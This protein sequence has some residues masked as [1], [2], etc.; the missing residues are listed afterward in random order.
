MK[1]FYWTAVAAC[2]LLFENRAC[3]E[4]VQTNGPCGGNIR[5]LAAVDGAVFAGTCSSGV[6]RST[7]NGTSWTEATTGLANTHV[8]SLVVSENDLFVGTWS[9]DVWRRQLSEMA[10]SG[11]EHPRPNST[12]KA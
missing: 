3:G 4:W 8:R 10:E 5:T 6:F 2:L 1:R 9:G 11:N 12:N 7:D